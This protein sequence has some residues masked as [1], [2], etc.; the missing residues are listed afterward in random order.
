MRRT[1]YFLTGRDSKSMTVTDL[2]Q[3]AVVTCA[4][5]TD[6]HTVAQLLTLRHIGSLPVIREDKT[7]VGLVAEYD[8]L[9]SMIQGRDLK[10]VTA[11]DIM[12]ERVLTVR[13]ETTMEISPCFFRIG[14]SPVFRSSEAGSS[15]AS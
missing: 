10:W 2:M 11:A 7:L 6:A 4:P 13:E 1:E 12:T 9:Q 14:M 5:H 3:D 8:L 15:S